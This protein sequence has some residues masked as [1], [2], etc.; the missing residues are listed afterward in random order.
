MIRLS[1]LSDYAI[2]L[3]CEM[4]PNKGQT[5]SASYLSKKTHISE[6]A[7]MKILK[8]LNKEGLIDSLR[9]PKGGY[10]FHKSADKLTIL[11]IVQAIDGPV[12]ITVCSH[13]SEIA[14]EFEENCIAKPGWDVINSALQQTL[15]SFTIQSFLSSHALAQKEQVEF[16]EK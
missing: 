6:A 3:M 16:I 11:D 15:A 10:I 4:A 14:C 5:F 9:G 13:D 2:S 8:A 1:R 7:V 12:A